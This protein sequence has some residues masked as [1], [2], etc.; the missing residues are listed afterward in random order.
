M[1]IIGKSLQQGMDVLA[2]M[3]GNPVFIWE[4]SSI[5][6]IPAAVTDANNPVAG[7]FQ[8]NVQA[9][10]LVKFDDW[11]TYDSTLI[12][13]DSTVYTV[14]VG[15]TYSRLQQE[16]GSLLLLENTDRIALTFAKPRPVVGRT[17]LY[18]G[19]TLRILSARQDASGAYYSLDLGAKTK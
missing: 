6:C 18:Q 5:K 19:R 14:D 17:L 3:L 9:R 7:G 12:T 1:T 8:D 4:G 10:V 11:Q 15:G 2:S 16:S 13:I